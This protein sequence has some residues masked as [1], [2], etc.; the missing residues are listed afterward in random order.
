MRPLG[1]AYLGAIWRQHPDR[2]LQ[3]LSPWVND[4]NRPISPLRSAEDLQGNTME[5]MK[6]VEDRYSG[7]FR[8]QGI[9][10]VGVGIR[11]FIVLSRAAVYRRIASGGSG[12]RRGSFSRCE[13]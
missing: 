10:G 3:P 9:V 13:C 8:T 7:R 1:D 4:R 12:R 2:N 6:A 5:R 11:T